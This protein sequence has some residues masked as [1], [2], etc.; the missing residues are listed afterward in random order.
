MGS[1]HLPPIK[2]RTKRIRTIKEVLSTVVDE[3]RVE[4][5]IFPQQVPILLP[6]KKKKIFSLL[7]VF[8]A[9]RKTIIPVDISRNKSQKTSIDPSNLHANDYS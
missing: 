2:A 3:N 9:K 1:N 6:R 4:A 5:K 7:N 8:F